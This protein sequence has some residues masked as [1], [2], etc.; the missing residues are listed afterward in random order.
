MNP[1][2]ERK[3]PCLKLRGAA[4]GT[5]RTACLDRACRDDPRIA[6]RT[7][8][9]AR[10]TTQ[11]RR[12]RSSDHGFSGKGLR[13][14]DRTRP[15]GTPSRWPRTGDDWPLQAASADWRRRVRR[16]VWP[17]NGSRWS[18]VALKII[19]LGMDTK[20]VVA[21]FEAERQALALMDHPNIA[22]VLDGG[23]ARVRP[24]LLRD[25]TGRGIPLTRFCDENHLG[26][27][28]RLELF[29]EV[30][31][32]IQHA[33]QKGIIHRD[34]KPSNILVTL[35]GEKP[36]PKVIDFGIAKAT[37]QRLTEKTL[38]TQFQQFIGTPAYMSPEQASLSGLDIDTRSD[39][40]S[41]GVLLYELLT[42]R[43]PFDAQSLLSAGY[44]EM[45]RILRE[46]EP[47]KP[48]TRVS[49][50]RD[51]ERTTV[52]RARHTDPKNLGGLIRG[53]LDW[54]V[55]KALEKNRT[56][57]YETAS[58]LALDIQR[59][60]ND[61]PVLAVAPS[62]RYRIG[63]F[64]RRHRAGLA[65]TA[66]LFA[67]L[68]TG[69]MLALIGFAQ[70]RRE[71]NRAQTE[72]PLPERSVNSAERSLAADSPWTTGPTGRIAANWKLLTVLDR[73]SGKIEGRFPDQP[74][75]RQPFDSR[76][77]DATEI[78]DLERAGAPY[79]KGHRD[80][81][82]GAG[83]GRSRTLEARPLWM[84]DTIPRPKQAGEAIRMVQQVL[85]ARRQVL[86][87]GSGR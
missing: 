63:K 74:L 68:V 73:A 14:L 36:V 11:R 40:Y 72:Q 45:R 12:R 15:F 21:R 54:I 24:P 33:H 80:L 9:D 41:L 35:H 57:R 10:Q 49:T 18:Q 75:V 56:R 38:Y 76:S 19:K 53:E 28:Q 29:T 17:S 87:E 37:Q 31:S 60:L 50:L 79:Q 62:A 69:L 48:S 86:G 64:V 43:T 77:V 85:D 71:R 30:C 47:P 82:T 52:A 27:R 42:S 84:G 3:R 67:V 22:V 58:A 6:P 44:E 46:E 13:N 23:A 83:A 20:Q 2:Q 55:M 81:R 4:S 65:V 78:F 51:E 66:S 34:L 61:E 16:G 25:G 70:A 39:I 59:H 26:T 1:R 8:S 32:A 5:E 7:G